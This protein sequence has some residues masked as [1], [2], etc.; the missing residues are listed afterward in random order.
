LKKQPGCSWIEVG[1][2]V[3]VFLARDK[4][5]YQSNLIYSLVH[6]I[7]AEMKAE[8]VPNNDFVDERKIFHQL[9]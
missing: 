6:D 7:H 3:H 9:R 2:R 4:S 8:H 5:H 1:N